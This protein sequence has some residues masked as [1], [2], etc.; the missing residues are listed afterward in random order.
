VKI[1][2]IALGLFLLV[3]HCYAEEVMSFSDDDLKRYSSGR[4][5]NTVEEGSDDSVPVRRGRTSRPLSGRPATASPSG[6]STG[7][8]ADEEPAITRQIQEEPHTPASD[9]QF[10]QPR[11]TISYDEALRMAHL[12]HSEAD[13]RFSIMLRPEDIRRAGDLRGLNA[14]QYCND[15]NK[16]GQKCYM[17]KPQPIVE[18]PLT[19]GRFCHSLIKQG[20]FCR[21]RG[22]QIEIGA[23]NPQGLAD[24]DPMVIY[25]EEF[26]GTYYV[27]KAIGD[28]KQMIDAP[29]A[30]VFV[31]FMSSSS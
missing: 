12:S 13:K 29:D 10:E 19:V 31:L 27:K 16:K 9:E 11:P 4:M 20:A 23:D 5:S 25:L 15:M 24:P 6:E 2:I 17:H 14:E 1:T 22:S 21:M 8:V 3:G 26:N 28:Q 7:P 18:T 30:G